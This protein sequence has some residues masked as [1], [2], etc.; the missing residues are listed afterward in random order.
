MLI[1]VKTK[2]APLQERGEI[3]K[4]LYFKYEH[5]YTHEDE[6]WAGVAGE[7]DQSNTNIPETCLRDFAVFEKNQECGH[8][9]KRS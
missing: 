2:K 6:E 5:N 4:L 9:Y 8:H 3:R 1:F 7:G